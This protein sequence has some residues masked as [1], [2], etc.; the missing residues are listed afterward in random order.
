[1]VSLRDILL[2]KKI[3]CCFI[4]KKECEVTASNGVVKL[5]STNS[6]DS[7]KKKKNSQKKNKKYDVFLEVMVV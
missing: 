4:I 2:V 7:P 5:N 6:S 3:T 1:M